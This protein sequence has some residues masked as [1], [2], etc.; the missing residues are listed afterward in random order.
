M[1]DIGRAVSTAGTQ[2]AATTAA[3][4]PAVQGTSKAGSTEA[5]V[6][7]PAPAPAFRTETGGRRT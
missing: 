6:P 4:T 7:V 1:P 3:G 5:P 2:T